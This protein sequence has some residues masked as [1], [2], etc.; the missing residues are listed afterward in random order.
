MCI[1]WWK[2]T[3]D[4]VSG[5]RCG[6]IMWTRGVIFRR[7]RHGFYSGSHRWRQ[8]LMLI[9]IEAT[10]EAGEGVK[11]DFRV[12]DQLSNQ[13]LQNKDHHREHSGT[14]SDA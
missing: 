6:L 13:D 5:P 12:V 14:C 11:R 2:S 7:V 8:L 3:S 10:M 4:C 9:F 1:A